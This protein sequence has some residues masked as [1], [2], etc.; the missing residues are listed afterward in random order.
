MTSKAAAA[1]RV[2][3]SAETIERVRMRIEAVAQADSLEE[4]RAESFFANG[5]IGALRA[6]GLLDNELY[7]TLEVELDKVVDEWSDAHPRACV[8]RN[9]PT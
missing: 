5:W 8:T 6:E 3:S 7:A 4:M 9:E 2:L 1:R